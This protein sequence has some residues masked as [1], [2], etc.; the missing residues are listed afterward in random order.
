MTQ[1]GRSAASSD[2]LSARL[3]PHDA[4][5]GWGMKRQPLFFLAAAEPEHAG[6]DRKGL[7]TTLMVRSVLA[8]PPRPTTG[9]PARGLPPSPMK[10][11][12]VSTTV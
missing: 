6:A 5:F 12:T 4:L 10:A 9:T 3:G 11:T 1:S 8:A 2:R 7:P